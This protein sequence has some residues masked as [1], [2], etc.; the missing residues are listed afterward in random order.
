MCKA[1]QRLSSPFQDEEIEALRGHG[2]SLEVTQLVTVGGAG[3]KFSV[4]LHLVH[5][6]SIRMFLLSLTLPM[7]QE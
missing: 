5:N 4:S 7:P 3:A 2:T 6:L 1:E